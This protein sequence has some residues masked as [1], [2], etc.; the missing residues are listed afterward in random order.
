MPI[1]IT[2]VIQRYIEESKADG[3]HRYLSWDHCQKSF[4][5]GQDIDLQALNLAYYL[6]SWG[7]YRGSGGLLQRNHKIHE[8]P[9]TIFHSG[10]YD[11]LKCSAAISV[12]ESS[13]DRILALRNEISSHYGAILFKRGND[14]S[15]PISATDTLMSKIM[16]GIFGC[17]PAFDDFLVNGMK[18]LGMKKR[19][20][21]EAGLKEI[22][23][24][25]RANE[26][27][28]TFCIELVRAE[29]KLGYYPVMKI[30]DMYLWQ[31]GYDKYLEELR[32]KKLK[33]KVK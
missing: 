30:I 3:F 11:D 21:D 13:I 2:S 4:A 22:F 7:M 14:P 28:I 33:G 20:F 19:K 5:H 10:R 24:F 6:A 15:K 31:I 12:Q 17:V 23:K 29:E 9:V 16:L 1:T 18:E 8:G 26:E 27:E 32:L 25:Y